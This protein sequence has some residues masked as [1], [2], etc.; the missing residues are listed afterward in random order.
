MASE[1]A[2]HFRLDGI[3][4]AY[5]ERYGLTQ[6]DL[7]DEIRDAFDDHSGDEVAPSV[8]QRAVSRWESGGKVSKPD[9]REA[10]AYFFGWR[11]SIAITLCDGG[12]VTA[13][14]AAS[15]NEDFLVSHPEYS[16]EYEEARRRETLPATTTT[17]VQPGDGFHAAEEQLRNA[18]G[19]DVRFFD[20]G[21]DPETGLPIRIVAP[22]QQ[23]QAIADI[24]AAAGAA[25]L[26]PQVLEP[27]LA[28]WDAHVAVF[29]G[30][31]LVALV[32]AVPV[33]GDRSGI[34]RA[35]ADAERS[36]FRAQRQAP[37]ATVVVYLVGDVPDDIESEARLLIDS[38]VKVVVDTEQLK[39]ALSGSG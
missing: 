23:G 10:L 27:K 3:L 9:A 29:D 35:V 39:S 36:A 18:M 26:R 14:E 22:G 34:E 28:G 21:V 37:D 24:S 11:H 33:V 30:G 32:D 6:Q 1:V 17:R 25:G 8:N 2:V 7:V 38:G 19:G 12:A 16:V 5:R 13:E 15:R 4:K 31:E 20:G